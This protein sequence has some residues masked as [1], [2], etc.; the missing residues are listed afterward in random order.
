MSIPYQKMAVSYHNHRRCAET[1]W[2]AGHDWRYHSSVKIGL[3]ITRYFNSRDNPQVMSPRSENGWGD[4]LI[5]GGA[6]PPHIDES[7]FRSWMSG[8]RIFVSSTIDD[9]MIPARTSAR[10]YLTQHNAE[11]VMWESITP[12][13]T[14]PQDAYIEGVSRS[15]L[16]VL[17]VGHRYGQSDTTGY[18]PT[19]KEANRASELGLTRLLFERAGIDLSQRDGRLNDWIKSI[20]SEVSAGQYDSTEELV[21][22]LDSRLRE[23]ASSQETYWVKLGDLVFPGLVRRLSSGGHTTFV[24]SAEVRDSAVRRAIGALT[25]R[26]GGQHQ[27]DRLTW[28]LETHPVRIEEVSSHAIGLSAEKVRITCVETEDRGRS[29]YAML[30][31]VTYVGQ[32]G[33]SF[34]PKDQ[35]AIWAEESLFSH[36][37]EG[38]AA[39]ALFM[40]A[41]SGEA[42]PS[43]TRVLTA[44]SALGWRAEGLIRVYLV[45]EFDRRFG[46]Y[47]SA[48]QVGPATATH[49]RLVAQLTLPDKQ[50]IAIRGLVPLRDGALA[51]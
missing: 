41:A 37:L 15:E 32:S 22:K 35:A 49:V 46:G 20:Y 5:D 7:R 21:A 30:G 25:Q 44:N 33:R 11:A 48:M 10:Q 36:R 14:R 2:I 9:E 27:A 47:V 6:S 8:L 50:G 17:L 26:G 39:H 18:S 1:S 24:V 23:V 51:S 4:L 29:S 34:G 31:G 45:E 19:H 42:A 38:G 13:D 3:P 43:L 16:F 12:L 28:A 40:R